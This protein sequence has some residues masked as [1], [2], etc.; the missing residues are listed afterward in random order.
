MGLDEIF[1]FV[2]IGAGYSDGYAGGFKQIKN[3]A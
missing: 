3:F 2:A 1:P